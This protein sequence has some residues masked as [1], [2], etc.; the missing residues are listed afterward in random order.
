MGF[1]WL[2]DINL[3]TTL[4]FN[5]EAALLLHT[6]NMFSDPATFK[7]QDTSALALPFNHGGILLCKTNHSPSSLLWSFFLFSSSF[8]LLPLCPR[9]LLH[10]DGL[11]S[12]GPLP[13][14]PGFPGFPRGSR[15]LAGGLFQ[16]EKSAHRASDIYFILLVWA[17]VLVQV[18]LNLWILQ[19]LPIPV[20]GN[21][22]MYS[23]TPS[24]M[25]LV[26]PTVLSD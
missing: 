11:P 18:W 21:T 10:Q 5:I 26:Q 16:K 8:S 24:H 6:V 1:R 13:P 12:A 9:T 7:E 19:L 23:H 15:S 2:M 20:A 17:I 14:T 3:Q 4:C 25:H 22:H